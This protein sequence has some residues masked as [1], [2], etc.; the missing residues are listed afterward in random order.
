MNQMT[1]YILCFVPVFVLVGAYCLLRFVFKKYLKHYDTIIKWF[2]RVTAGLAGLLFMLTIYHVE[3][4]MKTV[5]GSEPATLNPNVGC[6]YLTGEPYGENR[7]LN[8]FAWL[9][10][11]TV[12]PAVC[13]AFLSTFFKSKTGKFLNAF[14]L[15]PIL[16][17]NAILVANFKNA[18]VGLEGWDYKIIF[19]GLCVG[20]GFALSTI[21]FIDD[22]PELIEEFKS[23]KKN[24]KHLVKEVL[25]VFGFFLVTFICFLPSYTFSVLFN[26]NGMLLGTKQ[27]LLRVMDFKIAHRFFLYITFT[28]PLL[29]YFYCRERELNTRKVILIAGSLGA[30]TSFTAFYGAYD[31]FSIVDGVL[32]VHVTRLPIHLCHTALYVVPLCVAFNFK[33]LFYFTYFINVFGALM[34]MLWPNYDGEVNVFNPDVIMFWYNHI[35]ALVAPLLCVALGA[36]ERPKFK[37]MLWSLLFFGIYFIAVMFLNGWLSN[38]VAGYSPDVPGSGTDFLFINGDYIIE[39]VLGAGS[40]K[41]LDIKLQWTS[42][43]LIFVYYPVYQVLFFVGYIGIAFAMWF[44][45]SLFFKIA[46]SHH[47]THNRIVIMRKQHIHL[48][49]K[50]QMEKINNDVNLHEDAVLQFI[51][52]SKRYGNSTRLSADHVNLKVTGGQIFGFL[53]PNGAGKSTCIKTAIGIQPVTEGHI[54]VCGYDVTTQSVQSKKCIGYVPDHYALY[55]KLTGREYINY[56]ADLYGVSKEDRDVR[57]AKY[58]DLFELNQAFDNRMQTYSHGMKQKMTIIAALVH[59]PKVWILDEPLTGLDPQSIYQVKECMKNHAAEGNIVF[60][61]SHIIDVVEKL[62]TDIAIIKK[63]QIVYQNTM[64]NVLKEHPE[65]LEEFYMN[66]IRDN[67][68]LDEE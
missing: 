53:G 33:R 66:T 25:Y 36:F 28:Y 21:R 56:I 12:Y 22:L 1:L 54:E 38:Y 67:G 37:Q 41:L 35:S 47:D 40:R 4:I 59:N 18:L 3:G 31:M 27:T 5:G 26:T 43:S 13:L 8:F 39:N 61:S 16:L 7:V 14:V 2:L 49:E 65:G 45:Y 62:C 32:K 44:V 51:D 48:R 50:L 55:E 60:F 23:N 34:A 68:D 17:V 64:T 46:D 9:S 20:V 42:G 63:G 15:L 19:I 10:I 52:F 57:I 6:V 11:A 24:V 29:I 30:L 58:V